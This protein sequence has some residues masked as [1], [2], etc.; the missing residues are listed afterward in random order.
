MAYNNCGVIHNYKGN[1]TLFSLHLVPCKVPKI[2]VEP[3]SEVQ[4]QIIGLVW[5]WGC[6]VPDFRA[7][8]PLSCRVVL[9]V[10]QWDEYM[11]QGHQYQ[12]D[13]CA[14]AQACS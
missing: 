6:T 11:L 1:C 3:A 9:P 10:L 14:N 7:A 8:L 5:Q 13:H 2:P 4:L 12:N